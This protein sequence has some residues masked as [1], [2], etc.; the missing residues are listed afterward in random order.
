MTPFEYIASNPT[1]ED[2]RSKWLVFSPELAADLA[3]K[4]ASVVAQ[5]KTVHR[6]TPLRLTDGRYAVKCDLVTEI[7][8]GVFTAHFQSLDQGKL[9]QATVED[10]A[11]IR[12]LIPV[13]SDV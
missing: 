7:Q 4:Q 6:I 13:H 10:D 9:A 11:T 1:L 5:T 12:P 3:A 2:S 8:G